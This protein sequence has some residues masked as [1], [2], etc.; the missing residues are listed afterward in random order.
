LLVHVDD[1][2]RQPDKRFARAFA[3]LVADVECVLRDEEGVMEAAW[4]PGLRDRRRENARLLGA[5][6]HAASMVESGDIAVGREFTA[7]LPGLLALRR[8]G[9]L[10]MLN[11]GVAM[12]KGCMRVNAGFRHRAGEGTR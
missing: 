1:T 10:R 6:H 8:P 9:P 4:Y 12:R 2:A 7:A 11:H 5:L 3:N